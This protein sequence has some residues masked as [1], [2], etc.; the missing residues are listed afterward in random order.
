MPP[1]DTGLLRIHTYIAHLLLV[2]YSSVADHEVHN[3]CL[4]GKHSSLHTQGTLPHVSSDVGYLDFD[5]CPQ[6][7]LSEVKV[8]MCAAHTDTH[9]HISNSVF[10][11]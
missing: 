8:R 5:Y 4:V 3:I 10:G 6:G 11:C 7:Q 1:F 2:I 9:A